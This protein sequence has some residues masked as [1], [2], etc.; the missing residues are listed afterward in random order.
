MLVSRVARG[1]SS[2]GQI[3]TTMLRCFVALCLLLPI[4]VLGGSG[5]MGDTVCLVKKCGTTLVQCGLDKACRNWVSCVRECGDDTIKC[6]SL[7]GFFFQSPRINQT[8]RC[9]FESSCINLGFDK[10]ATYEHATRPVEPLAGVAG[11]YWFA[12][13][14][15]GPHIFDYDCQ[16]FD[17]S[18]ADGAGDR[19]GVHFSVPLT[20]KG[21]NRMTA[22]QGVFAQTPAG[23]LLVKYENFSGYDEKWYLVDKTEQTILAQVC[24]DTGTVCYN[25]GTILLARDDLSALDPATLAHLDGVT[26]THFGFSVSDF[27][28]SRVRGCPNLGAE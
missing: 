9:I 18:Q 23:P 12:A 5:D 25:Y 13:S 20:Y 19:L 21:V 3:M 11:T 28:S 4:P 26:R 7:C 24:I 8:S 27:H 17:F 2:A 10:L 22:A 15:G 16:R 14:H 1:L 6:P